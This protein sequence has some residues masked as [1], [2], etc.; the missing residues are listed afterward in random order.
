M[1]RHILHN[2]KIPANSLCWMIQVAAVRQYST[3]VISGKIATLKA[4]K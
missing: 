1:L 2:I 3:L 4:T